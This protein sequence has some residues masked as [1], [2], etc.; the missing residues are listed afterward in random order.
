MDDVSIDELKKAVE[1]MHGV[2][3]RFTHKL[4]YRGLKNRDVWRWQRA[5]LRNSVTDT[6]RVRASR[7]SI[8][9]RGTSCAL[10][11]STMVMP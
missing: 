5:H 8:A 9:N 3:A 2:P 1:H 11:D 10:P 6:P 7:W 4:L